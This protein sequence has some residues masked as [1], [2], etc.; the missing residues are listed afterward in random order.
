MVGPSLA[1]AAP[2]PGSCVLAEDEA[3]VPFAFK[4]A[5]VA[6]FVS[7]QSADRL[8]VNVGPGGFLPMMVPSDVLLIRLADFLDVLGAEFVDGFGA[9]FFNDPVKPGRTKKCKGSSRVSW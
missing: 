9:E 7:D 1:F 3:V 6:T 2:L 8:C 4:A 5:T